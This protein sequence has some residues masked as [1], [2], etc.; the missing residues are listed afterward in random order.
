MVSYW[1]VNTF[2]LKEDEISDVQKFL[3]V[4]RKRKTNNYINFILLSSKL[5]KCHNRKANK[6]YLKNITV[7]LD[8]KG[9]SR[10]R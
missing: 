10:I 9:C 7:S 5:L 4:H 6:N 3:T 1:L 8:V 2:L